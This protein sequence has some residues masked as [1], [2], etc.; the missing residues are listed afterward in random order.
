MQENYCWG[1]KVV[2]ALLLL[3]KP[4]TDKFV[5]CASTF[6]SRLAP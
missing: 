2:I 6:D 4:L 1:K 3:C 5:P